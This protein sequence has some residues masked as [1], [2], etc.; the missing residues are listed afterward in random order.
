M[1]GWCA[2]FEGLGCEEERLTLF[3][4]WLCTLSCCLLTLFQSL[5]LSQTWVKHAEAEITAWLEKNR[6]HPT[7]RAELNLA[8][9]CDA[10]FCALFWCRGRPA[11]RELKYCI[12]R[13]GESVLFFREG[14]CFPFHFFMH[15]PLGRS[16][17]LFGVVYLWL[18]IIFPLLDEVLVCF[19]LLITA[20]LLFC[21]NC[22]P[23]K[24]TTRCLFY[25]YQSQVLLDCLRNLSLCA[26][27]LCC[28]ARV[29]PKEDVCSSSL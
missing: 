21:Q 15:L 19:F 10:W 8:R 29:I 28:V 17:S 20:W 1:R 11:F 26:I 6:L 13:V 2:G 24:C 22:Y 9:C 27:I 23:W 7:W 25:I 18:F 14:W 16:I 4:C 5:V 12:K 3:S